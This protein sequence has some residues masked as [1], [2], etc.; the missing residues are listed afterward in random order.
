[1]KT[2][3]FLQTRIQLVIELLDLF[4]DSLEQNSEGRC[5]RTKFRFS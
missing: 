3:N 1:L 5:R 2:W 4:K